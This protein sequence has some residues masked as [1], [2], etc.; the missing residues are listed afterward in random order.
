MTR[1][2][3]GIRLRWAL[4]MLAASSM[5]PVGAARA[6]TCDHE[7]EVAGEVHLDGRCT[8]RQAFTISS[9]GTRLDCHGATLDGEGR[10]RVGVLVDSRGRD[11]HDVEVRNCIIRGYASNAVRV[12][13]GAPD[14]SKTT[15][16]QARRERT[17]RNVRLAGLQVHDA[18]RV[19]VYFDDHVRDSILEDSRIEGSGGAAVYLEFGTRGIAVRNNV[20]VRNGHALRREALAVDAS[21]G[22]RIEG[23]AFVD[24][25]QGGIFLYKNCGERAGSGRSVR[26]TQHSDDNRIAGNLFVR[27]DVGVWIAS[28]QSRNLRSQ[29]CL[30]APMGAK[31]EYFEDYANRN[32]V[33]DNTFCGVRVGIRVE[34]DDNRIQ[35]NAF[36]GAT[37]L[38]VEVPATRRGEL[39]HRPPAGNVLDEGRD[40]ETSCA[41]L[42]D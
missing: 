4:V 11:L 2:L 14:A 17:P 40:G 22:N 18:G 26:R 7:P 21:A 16:A 8:Y 13:W 3:H 12:T 33:E 31:R 32:A 29:D 37:R 41:H 35:G 30:D 42:H 23:N 20:L 36:D 9:S 1:D 10:R 5:P 15:D 28:R 39:L 24:N 19:G 34:G 25:R 6:A 38:R 27:E